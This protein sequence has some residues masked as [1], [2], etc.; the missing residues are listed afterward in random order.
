VVSLEGCDCLSG[1]ATKD[2]IDRAGIITVPL[3][4][5][6]HF[7]HDLVRRQVAVTINWTV[8][9]IV[10]VWIVTPR[11][12]PVAR[13]PEIPASANKDDAVVVAAPPTPIM[14]LP[15]VI[16]KRS[17]LLPTK[18]AAPPIVRDRHISVSV[19]TDVRG[20]VAG[21]SPV[22]KASITIDRDVTSDPSLIA[23]PHI[24][25]SNPRI[26]CGI[27]A[28]GG[29]FCVSLAELRIRRGVGPNSRVAIEPR[30][31]AVRMCPHWRSRNAALRPDGRRSGHLP[32]AHRR[33]LRWRVAARTSMDRCCGSVVIVLFDLGQR[34]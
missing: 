33:T 17:I 24:A 23:E 4:L 14:P 32:C 34:R 1:H 28:N 10:S 9:R 22:T 25:I 6:L 29:V 12:I 31:A 20:G 15:V 26:R 18:S 2:A 11:W 19:D 13:I 5:S 16:S 3:Q 8:V 30:R 27:R 21:E 7:D